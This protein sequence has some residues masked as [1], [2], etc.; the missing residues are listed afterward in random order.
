MADT[1]TVQ[2][3]QTY[4]TETSGTEI[5][6]PAGQSDF[7][8]LRQASQHFFNTFVRALIHLARM[9]VSQM[10]EESREHFTNAVGEFTRGLSTLAHEL[11]NSVEKVA[12]E[13]S[14]HEKKDVQ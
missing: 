1:T 7:E 9:P 4:T 12:E 3:E 5:P 8:E 10:S 6:T 14:M 11:A 13:V 2:A